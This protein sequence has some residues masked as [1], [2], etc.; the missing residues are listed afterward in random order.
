[1]ANA[2]LQICNSCQHEFRA[3]TALKG[4]WT[5]CPHC[6]DKIMIERTEQTKDPLV[7]R[8]VHGYRL[9]RRIGAGSMAAVYLAVDGRTHQQVAIKLLSTKAA[10]DLELVR[11]FQR[12]ANLCRRLEHPNIVK[13]YEAGE[14]KGAHFLILEYVDGISLAQIITQEERLPWKRAAHIVRAVASAL[15]HT[16]SIGVLHR[17]IKPGNILVTEDGHVKLV[18]LGLGKELDADSTALTLQGS[19]MGT[20]AYMAPEQIVDSSQVAHTADIYAPGATFYHA[21]VG[22]QPYPGSTAAEIMHRLRHD[23]ATPPGEVVPDLPKGINDLI[24]FMLE[25]DPDQRPQ[26]PAELVT[27]ID[28]ALSDPSRPVR[29]RRRRKRKRSGHG[30]TILAL[31]VFLILAVAAAWLVLRNQLVI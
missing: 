16:R 26:D 12:E 8:E 24:C 25:R 13:A 27:V 5:M 21:V 10:K 22:R 2:L 1:M 14:E 19:C 6:G 30:A 15:N 29:H 20:P 7:G 31:I 11:R 18:D 3:P 23:T 4:Q 17:D 9:E 28:E